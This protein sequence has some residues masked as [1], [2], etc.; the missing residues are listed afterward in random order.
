LLSIIFGAVVAGKSFLAVIGGSAGMGM[1]TFTASG[2]PGD[3]HVTALEHY[4]HAIQIPSLLQSLVLLLMS[5]WLILLGVGQ[6]RYRAWAAR[7]SVLWGVIG[8][9]VMVGMVALYLAVIGP[10]TGRMMEETMQQT[11][12]P[13]LFGS[14]ARWTGIAGL[15][16]YAP[17]PIILI[18]TFRKPSIVSAMR[19]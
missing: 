16:F 3:P 4:L 13:N 1:M 11:D 12:A 18:A 5:V 15:L 7:Q 14:I 9:A 6:R 10:A 17:Y 8:L 19:T 2:P